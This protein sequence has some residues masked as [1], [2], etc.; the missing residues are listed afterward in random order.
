M[1]DAWMHG[2]TTFRHGSEAPK[3]GEGRNCQRIARITLT[4]TWI[5]N[6]R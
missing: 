5:R 1:N 4:E 2:P 3:P 6:Q